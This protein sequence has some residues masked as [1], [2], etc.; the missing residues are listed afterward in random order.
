[1]VLELLSSSNNKTWQIGSGGNAVKNIYVEDLNVT[2]NLVVDGSLTILNVVEHMIEDPVIMLG[3]GPSGE[4]LEEPDLKDRGIR[5]AYYDSS[6]KFGF[7]GYDTSTGTF[8]FLTDT[9]FDPNTLASNTLNTGTK[10]TIFANLTGNC[11]GTALTVTQPAQTTITSVGTLTA[12]QVD[13]LNVDGNTITATS[14]AVNITPAANSAIVLDGTINIDAGVVTGATSIT[15]TAFVGALT[16]NVTGNADT[17]TTVTQPAQTTITSVGT[18]TALQVDNLNVDGNT[19]TATSGAVNIT[20][21]ANSAIVLDGTINIDA[22][23]VTGAT[24]IT[25][26]AFVGALTGNVTGNADTA[27]TV[28]QPAQTTITSVGTLTALQVDNLN[29]DGN[30]IRLLWEICKRIFRVSISGSLF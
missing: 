17:A 18:L 24:S 6:Y 8:K 26:T 7:M 27:T 13:N 20:P 2:H 25:S 9:T 14:G 16:G 10:G 28:T 4:E 12:L 1:M 15:S 30:T 21:A 3:T 29:V 19:I 11:S 22:G 5:F 23:V